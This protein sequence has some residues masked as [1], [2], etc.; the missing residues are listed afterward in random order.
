VLDSTASKPG[1]Q[2]NPSELST[3]KGIVDRTP[4]RDISDGPYT[5]EVELGNGHQWRERQ[6]GAWCRFSEDPR[7]FLRDPSGNLQL[8]DDATKHANMAKLYE[9]PKLAAFSF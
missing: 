3:E 5:K 9:N 4:A 6:D 7:C 2:L 8:I 1:D